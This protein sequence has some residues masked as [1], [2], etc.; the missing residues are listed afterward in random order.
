MSQA[1]VKASDIPKG[2]TPMQYRLA[3]AIA[4]G[5]MTWADAMEEAGYS[6]KTARSDARDIRERP[7]VVRASE[8]IARRRRDSSAEI[9]R[10]SSAAVLE[11]LERA[12]IDPTFALNSWAT[13]ARIAAEYPEGENDDASDAHAAFLAWRKKRL[14]RAI[15]LALVMFGRPQHLVSAPTL[16]G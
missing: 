2:S 12:N 5:A 13:S 16:K 11:E 9:R 14:K 15:H 7:G 3:L 6:P 1:L 10:K 4:N 8:A